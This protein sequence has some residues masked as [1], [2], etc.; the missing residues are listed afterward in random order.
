MIIKD[1]KNGDAHNNLA[2][3]FYIKQENLDVAEGYALRA[4]E[5]NPLKAE[6]YRDTLEKIRELKRSQ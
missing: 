1:P 2:W 4:M 6:I 5:L 3:L